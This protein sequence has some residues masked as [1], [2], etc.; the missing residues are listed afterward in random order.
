MARFAALLVTLVAIQLA[1][2]Q[3]GVTAARVLQQL[4][5]SGFADSL[6]QD[7]WNSLNGVA[8]RH[9]QPLQQSVPAAQRAA[10]TSPSGGSGGTNTA[11]DVLSMHNSLRAQHGSPAL[12]WSQALVA[13]SQS[14]ANHLAS[15]CTFYHSGPG[16]NLASGYNSW[17]D[18][19]S[20]FYNEQRKNFKVKA[21]KHVKTP[22]V[23]LPKSDGEWRTAPAV[24]TQNSHV[25]AKCRSMASMFRASLGHHKKVLCS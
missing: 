13:S 17:Q 2:L 5:V 9:F 18:V 12:A 8:Q 3:E 21:D 14:W 6:I 23:L 25:K 16:E 10:S 15:T 19:I 20:A 24:Q 1:I 4:D 11:G 7:A 22:T